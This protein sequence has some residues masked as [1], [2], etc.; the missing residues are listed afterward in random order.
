MTGVALVLGV[1]LAAGA[2]VLVALPFLREPVADDDRL[3]APS[4]AEERR[5]RARRGARPRARGAQGARVRPSHGQD[6]RRRLPSRRRAAPPGGGRRAQATRRGR[7]RNAAETRPSCRRSS[8]PGR[9]NSR[10]CGGSHARTRLC[11]FWPRHRRSATTSRRSTRSTR[12]SPSLQGTLAAHKQQEQALR[13]QVDGYTSRI[14]ALESARRR[15][16]AAAAR[17]SRPTSRCI[18]SGSTRSTRSS[19]SRRSDSRSSSGSTRSR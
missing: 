7:T 3:D 5:A 19:R 11:C 10:V 9:R 4:D 13:S 17:R 18:R 14:R 2:V 8:G 16:L 1:V 15:R 12:R 6:H